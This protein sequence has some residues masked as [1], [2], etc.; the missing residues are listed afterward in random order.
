VVEQNH[1]AI[2]VQDKDSVVVS[3]ELAQRLHVASRADPAPHCGE[4]AFG[5]SSQVQARSDGIP[6]L[7][8]NYG[9]RSGRI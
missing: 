3:R 7:R 1:W 8:K 9:A 6:G 4:L 2:K 5:G